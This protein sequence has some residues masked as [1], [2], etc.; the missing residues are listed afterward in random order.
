MTTTYFRL[1]FL[2]L[3]SLG[4]NAVFAQEQEQEQV[5]ETEDQYVMDFNCSS[6][7]PDGTMITAIGDL[8]LTT[9]DGKVESSL[10]DPN[11]GTSSRTLRIKLSDKNV[12]L[13][14]SKRSPSYDVIQ[15]IKGAQ[16]EFIFKL[17]MKVA[18]NI[19][20]LIIDGESFELLCEKGIRQ[21]DDT[22]TYD[23]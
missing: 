5:P 17:P 3:L 23:Y 9:M 12:T 20:T 6:Y 2:F 21:A 16:L 8:N 13:Q 14:E 4:G 11:L 22:E 15:F 19:A 7:L 18:D 10:I 1:I